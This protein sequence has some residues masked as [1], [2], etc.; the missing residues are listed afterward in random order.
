MRGPYN[1][2]VRGTGGQFEAADTRGS[3][4]APRAGKLSSKAGRWTLG[5]SL[6][7]CENQARQFPPCKPALALETCGKKMLFLE[8]WVFT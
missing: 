1:G 7:V 4:D 3:L 2:A 5:P 8:S 6:P